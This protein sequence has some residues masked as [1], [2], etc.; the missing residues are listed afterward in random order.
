MTGLPRCLAAVSLGCLVLAAPCRAEEEKANEKPA[1]MAGGA[2]TYYILSP[3]FTLFV[4]VKL[5]VS[6]QFPFLLGF[7][8]RVCSVSVGIHS[9][10]SGERTWTD[11]PFKCPM[12]SLAR[13]K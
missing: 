12:S 7:R 5:P 13:R 6:P 10:G 11:S 8:N 9:G 1:G 2:H 4:W 3:I